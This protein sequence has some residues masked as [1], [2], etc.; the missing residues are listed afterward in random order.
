[1]EEIRDL[2]EYLVKLRRTLHQCPEL[3]SDLPRTRAVLRAELEKL[4][5]AVTECAGGLVAEI[6]GGQAAEPEEAGPVIVLRADMDALPMKEESG[7]PFAATGDA[8]HTCGH[9]I[10]AAMLVGAARLLA[11]ERERLPG[12]VRLV[13][14]PDEETGQ[15]ARAMGKA[16]VLKGAR[17]AVGMHVRPG[18]ATGVVNCTAGDK[19]ASYDRFAITIHGTG[20]HGAMPHLAADPI[21]VGSR[22]CLCC[23]EL[24]S[25]ECPPGSGAV[26]TVGSFHA[27]QSANTIPPKARLEGTIRAAREEE[28]SLLRRRLPEVA[29][30]IASAFRTKAEIDLP[31]GVPV[32]YNDPDLCGVLIPALQAELGPE[33]VD[34]EIQ[35]LPVSEDFALMA[36]EVPAVY[37][38]IG[39]GEAADGYCYGNHHPAVRY[40]EAVLEAGARAYRACAMALL[41]RG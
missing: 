5:L 1:M 22:I 11:K 9:D 8:A 39:T 4:E 33:A 21:Q 16:G 24:I 30:A 14:Q 25:A 17:A 3:G 18:Q 35:R 40:D 19:T 27:G 26:V 23:Q 32:V 31:D 34:T 12:T 2:Q 20:G 15:G 29:E 38:T 36:K 7:L 10:H 13:F 41:R 6:S 28:R 37:L